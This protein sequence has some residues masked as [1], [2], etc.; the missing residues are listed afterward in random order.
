MYDDD[1]DASD[2]AADDYND[3]REAAIT[4]QLAL[5]VVPIAEE[6]EAL[7]YDREEGKWIDNT[8]PWTRNRY[9]L[10]IYDEDG[11]DGLREFLDE[12][13]RDE[14]EQAAED[15][16]DPGPCCNQFSCPCGN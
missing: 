5:L 13:L 15:A 9:L 14:A 7:D 12:E 4:E 8:H 2:A 10:W 6:I 1:Y 11:E 3:A 16:Y